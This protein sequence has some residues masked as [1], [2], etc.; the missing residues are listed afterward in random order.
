MPE[1]EIGYCRVGKKSSIFDLPNQLRG[2]RFSMDAMWDE[3]SGHEPFVDH[4][5]KFSR[6][7]IEMLRPPVAQ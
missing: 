7:A 3:E 4:P 6:A 1:S 2:F 5:V